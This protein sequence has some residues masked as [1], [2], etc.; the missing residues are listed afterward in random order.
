M[1]VVRSLCFVA[2]LG[3]VAGRGLPAREPS[4]QAPITLSRT[5]GG[6][7]LEWAVGFEL[8]GGYG[9]VFSS[10][11]SLCLAYWFVA[12]HDAGEDSANEVLL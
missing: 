8:L 3:W 9:C 1:K 12:C 10:L 6:N 2:L 11:Q 7:G 4:D 5:G